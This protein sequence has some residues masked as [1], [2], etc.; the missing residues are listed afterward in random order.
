MLTFSFFGVLLAS[1]VQA[2][3]YD[4][5]VDPANENAFKSIKQ[6]IDAAPSNDDEP[7]VIKIAAGDFYEKVIITKSNIQLRGAGA[8]ET[9]LHFDAYSGQAVPGHYHHEYPEI[10]AQSRDTWG[11]SLSATLIVRAENFSAQDLS[12]ENSFDYPKNDS[13]PK[14]HPDKKKHSQAVA[15]MLDKGSDKAIFK[16]V[17]LKGFQDTLFADAGRSVFI[18]SY[19]SGHVDFIFGAGNSLF[20]QSIIHTR[21]RPGK[22]ATIG[23]ITAPSTNIKQT[24][25]FVFLESRLTKDKNVSAG[26]VGLGRPWHPTTSF[27]D[28]RYGDPNAIGHTLFINTWMDDHIQKDPWHNMGAWAKDGSRMMYKGADARFYEYNS[29]GPGAH[30]TESRRRLTEKQMRQFSSIIK[31]LDG[32]DPINENN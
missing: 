6:A 10:N 17:H 23:Y 8:T 32:W 11:T 3:E 19:I 13:L 29:S 26:S 1:I 27:D 30:N 9:R 2:T 4:A 21:D 12:I 15:L 31:L 22:S 5:L 18:N 7:Y 20:Y 25:G 16:R 28:G 24:T 14:N